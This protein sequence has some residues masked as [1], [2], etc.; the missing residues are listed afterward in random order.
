MLRQ[1]N[2]NNM[3]RKMVILISKE[4][5]DLTEAVSVEVEEVIVAEEVVLIII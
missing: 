5:E 1:K 2:G 4:G 3:Y